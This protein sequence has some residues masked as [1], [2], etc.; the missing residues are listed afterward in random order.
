MK[1]DFSLVSNLCFS[2]LAE[3]HSNSAMFGGTDSDSFKIKLKKIK[4]RIK[5]VAK[6]QEQYERN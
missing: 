1:E 3:V 6:Y 2:A 4:Q 5:Q